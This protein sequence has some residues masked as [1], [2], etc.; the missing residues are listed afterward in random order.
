MPEKYSG[1]SCSSIL[2]GK[3]ETRITHLT[4]KT[5]ELNRSRSRK[6]LNHFEQKSSRMI[7]FVLAETSKVVEHKYRCI[8]I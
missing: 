1:S 8:A 7:C 3:K 6:N 5:H 4:G 2:T